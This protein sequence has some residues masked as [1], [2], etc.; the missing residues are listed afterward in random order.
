MYLQFQTWKQLFYNWKGRTFV[1]KHAKMT[2][3]NWFFAGKMEKGKYRQKYLYQFHS[4]TNNSIPILTLH[5]PRI[6]FQWM[7]CSAS[8]KIKAEALT[9]WEKTWDCSKGNYRPS[10]P[11]AVQDR[12]PWLSPQILGGM[13]NQCHL[14][15]HNRLV[16]LWL[17]S[18]SHSPA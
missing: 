11:G 18:E 1:F 14:E 5:Y 15:D 9:L 6:R 8:F 2:C 3:S 17:P 4:V 13:V 10:Q 7:K 16:Q 12:V